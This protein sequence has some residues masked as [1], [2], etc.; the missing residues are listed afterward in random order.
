MTWSLLFGL[1][2]G[3]CWG[4]ADFV[5]GLQA[6]RLPALVV[7]LWSQLI[8]GGVLFAALIVLGPV[9]THGAL[10]GVA[11]GLCGGVALVLFYRALAM[12]TMSLIAPVSACGAVV[13]V[14]VGLAQGEQLG[15]LT[16]G[17][18][19]AAM[20]GIVLVSLTSAGSQQGRSQRTAFALALGAA[21]GFGL[22]LTLIDRAASTPGA[23]AL[24]VNVWARVGSVSLLLPLQLVSARGLGWP[25]R[26]LPMV[27]LGGLLDMSANVL[28][29]LATQAGSLGVAAV[30]GSLYPVMTVLLSW[31]VLSE[32]LRRVQYVGV[33]LALLGIGLLAAG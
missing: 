1:S 16:I 30:L 18:I 22:F 21:L 20:V 26:A 29:A 6:R 7:T 9:M 13:P 32:R 28:Y 19:G 2:S 5:G 10:W 15:P 14:F 31:V 17:G 25:G 8:G 11:A 4:A 33:G 12:G 24:W 3:L 23:S 27:G